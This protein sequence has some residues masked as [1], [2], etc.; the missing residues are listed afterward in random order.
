[1][2]KVNIMIHRHLFILDDQVCNE[3][4]ELNLMALRI[5]TLKGTMK[6][7]PGVL[8]CFSR[9][10]LLA[11]GFIPRLRLALVAIALFIVAN[12]LWLSYLRRHWIRLAA[13]LDVSKWQKSYFT[14]FID[15]LTR[16]NLPLGYIRKYSPIR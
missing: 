13:E 16:L 8:V 11:W 9:L 15:L 12:P 6:T 14:D 5:R 3:R 1:M 10:E 7:K 2:L 4:H